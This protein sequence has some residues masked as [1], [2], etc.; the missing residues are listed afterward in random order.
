MIRTLAL[1]AGLVIAAPTLAVAQDMDEGGCVFDRMI[2]P[3]GYELCQSGTLKRCESGAWADIGLCDEEP[4]P[5]PRSSG[6][7][8][9]VEPDRLPVRR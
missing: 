7:D 6:G 3:E 9:V 5:P 8:V 1:A 4:R 2:Y